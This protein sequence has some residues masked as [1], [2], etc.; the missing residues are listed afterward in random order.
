[1][2]LAIGCSSVA[3]GEAGGVHWGS[4]GERCWQQWGG[5]QQRGGGGNRGSAVGVSSTSKNRPSQHKYRSPKQF[6][7]KR[8]RKALRALNPR[9]ALPVFED[10]KSKAS[11]EKSVKRK[12]A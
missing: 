12:I 3:T 8:S 7:L 4:D 5:G 10:R 6:K 2:F 11:D 9:W 1:M